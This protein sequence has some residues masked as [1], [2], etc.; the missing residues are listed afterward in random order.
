MVIETDG[1]HALIAGHMR[2]TSR[3]LTVAFVY[4]G[5]Q[6]GAAEGHP[7]G[8]EQSKRVLELFA[9]AAMRALFASADSLFLPVPTGEVKPRLVSVPMPEDKP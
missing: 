8:D 9:S 7:I 1:L 3:E 4:S 5:A 6:A 2:A